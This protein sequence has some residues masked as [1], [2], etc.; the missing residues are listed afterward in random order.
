MRERYPLRYFCVIKQY[1][2]KRKRQGINAN[3]CVIM[4]AGE[5]KQE[6]LFYD[7]DSYKYCNVSTC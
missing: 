2:E 6:G 1:R 5:R 7:T 3:F 4:S